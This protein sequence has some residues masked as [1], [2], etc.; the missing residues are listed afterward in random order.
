M[1]GE[2]EFAALL[3]R[4]PWRAIRDCPGRYALIAADAGSDP[5]RILGRPARLSEHRSAMA[6]DPIVLA[7]FAAGGGLI[8]YRRDDGRW[9]HTLNDENGW[10]RKRSQLGIEAA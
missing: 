7:P 3:A 5:E 2:D 6:R 8:S 4:W 9:L 1:S 10:T